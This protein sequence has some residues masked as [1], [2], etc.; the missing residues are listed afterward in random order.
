M[1]KNYE[2]WNYK[3]PTGFYDKLFSD[4]KEKNIGLQSTWHDLTFLKVK[5]FIK[6]NDNHL[7]YACGPGTFIGNYLE[8]NSIGYDIAINQIE[9]ANSKYS[10]KNK[11]F[12]T[13]KK[14]ILLKEPFDVITVMAL[15][16]VL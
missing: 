14:E 13:S 16:E 15:I 4:G 5:K 1:D 10:D 12:T 9:Y 11:Y 7:D 8:C 3:L 6:N 2:F